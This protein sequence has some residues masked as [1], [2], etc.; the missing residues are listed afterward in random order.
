MRI[1]CSKSFGVDIVP[2]EPSSVHTNSGMFGACSA[3]S[4][5]ENLWYFGACDCDT[6]I[7]CDLEIRSLSGKIVEEDDFTGNHVTLKPC[8]QT[9]FA[10]TA[11][12][13][14]SNLYPCDK[15]FLNQCGG[16][17]SETK[18]EWY[19]VRRLRVFTTNF[20]VAKSTEYL[21]SSLDADA[22]AT[23]RDGDMLHCFFQP[24]SPWM[25]FFQ[26]FTFYL[27]IFR[28]STIKLCNLH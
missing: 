2:D 12:V 5:G 7:A 11:I 18:E 25:V 20:A 13:P 17:N 15:D 8:V 27:A 23:V 16:K 24:L 1:R 14:A 28:F 22:L 6:T 9:A 26:L 4:R 10:Y 19:T 21:A 3:D